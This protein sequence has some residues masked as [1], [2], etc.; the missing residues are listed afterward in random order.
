MPGIYKW[1]KSNE[2]VRRLSDGGVIPNDSGNRD[3]R[4]FQ[5]WLGQGN[6]PD[7]EDTPPSAGEITA[8]QRTLA[9]DLFMTDPQ[10]IAKVVR[11]ASLVTMDE[12]NRLSQAIEGLKGALTAAGTTTIATLKS[13]VNAL[14]TLQDRQATQIKTAIQNKINGGP[15][16]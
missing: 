4:E 11:G 14:P 15:A 9:V 10:P 7:P 13:A 6:T 1:I 2:I 3:W 12:I 8:S 5:G 16:D